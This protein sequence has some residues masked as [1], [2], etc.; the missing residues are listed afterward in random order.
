MDQH[1]ETIFID[2]SYKY[3]QNNPWLTMKPR[4][5]L[6]H[7]DHSNHLSA[8]CT[9]TPAG[10]F[11]IRIKVNKP[12][13]ISHCAIVL[14]MPDHES[15]EIAP[16][17]ARSSTHTIYAV[18]NATFNVNQTFIK[19]STFTHTTH[20]DAHGTFHLRFKVVVASPSYEAPTRAPG[21]L[22][23]LFSE[24]YSDATVEVG[25]TNVM[26]P[27][28]SGILLQA[29][30]VFAN[31]F[32]TSPRDSRWILRLRD[33][34]EVA[35]RA[36]IEYAYLHRVEGL[37]SMAWQE[38]LQLYELS[39]IYEVDALY[40]LVVGAIVDSDMSDTTIFKIIEVFYRYSD[41]DLLQECRDYLLR[42][43]AAMPEEI[44]VQ[45]LSHPA[46]RVVICEVNRRLWLSNK[47][48]QGRVE[49]LMDAY[50]YMISQAERLSVSDSKSVTIRDEFTDVVS[51]STNL[52]ERT[53]GALVLVR[54]KKA[55]L[56]KVDVSCEWEWWCS[57]V[58]VVAE[59]LAS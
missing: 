52:H 43:S 39:K 4:L 40:R 46:G 37:A 55:S 34:S 19:D 45:G 14:D 48:L 27:V 58:S 47:H 38:K 24:A 33:T 30:R 28:S 8:T 29:S 16:S 25:N 56:W 6:A 51:P 26:I 41:I 57:L 44:F 42:H 36:M 50:R 49:D 53:G 18:Y 10:T 21:S 2:S 20:H 23:M 3:N 54:P 12:K 13:T 31:Q 35:V 5:V 22:F 59:G 11:N 7:R 32:A 17:L 9:Y 1:T 15:L